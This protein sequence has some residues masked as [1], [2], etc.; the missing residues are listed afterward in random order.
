MS[1]F[2]PHLVAAGQGGELGSTS[3]HQTLC[4]IWHRDS[5]VFCTGPSRVTGQHMHAPAI[6]G[7]KSGGPVIGTRAACVR[8]RRATLERPTRTG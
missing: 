7:P 2:V 6:E 1:R 5:G 4:E 3:S 8:A